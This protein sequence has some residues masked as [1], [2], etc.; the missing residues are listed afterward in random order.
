M[1]RTAARLSQA[2]LLIP[3]PFFKADKERLKAQI[4]LLLTEEDEEE[5]RADVT[6]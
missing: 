1:K 4:D 3:T 5:A 6:E 2:W